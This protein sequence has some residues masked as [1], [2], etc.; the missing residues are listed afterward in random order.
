MFR[1][2][3]ERRFSRP[4][5]A[6]GTVRIGRSAALCG[7]AAIIYVRKKAADEAF[8]PAPPDPSG[9]GWDPALPALAVGQ[10]LHDYCPPDQ[11]ES[12]FFSHY[13]PKTVEWFNVDPL[14]NLFA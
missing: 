13:D 1:L 7:A 5:T 10:Y 2:W 6:A 14:M 9:V 3:I 8:F 4:V 12:R 11:S